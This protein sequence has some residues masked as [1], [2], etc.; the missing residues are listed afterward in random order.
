MFLDCITV[1]G[2]NK[3]D[4]LQLNLSV[5][6]AI[7]QQLTNHNAP[8]LKILYIILVEFQPGTGKFCYFMVLFYKYE[9]LMWKKIVKNFIFETKKIIQ[10][11]DLHIQP[12][13]LIFL[14]FLNDQK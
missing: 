6:G 5:F 10:N 11:I 7:K 12:N 9:M 13:F 8:F 1:F 2:K 3:T 14:L 4:K